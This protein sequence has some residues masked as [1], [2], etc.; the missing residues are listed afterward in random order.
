MS[1]MNEQGELKEDLKIPEEEWL[2]DVTDRVKAILADG[3]KECIVS[4]IAAMGTEKMVSA[5][6]GNNI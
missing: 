6:E 5:K 4:V 2:K 1:L 3:K